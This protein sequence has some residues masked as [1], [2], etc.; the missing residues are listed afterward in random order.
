MAPGTEPG[1]TRLMRHPTRFSF[2]VRFA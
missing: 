2:P 1:R